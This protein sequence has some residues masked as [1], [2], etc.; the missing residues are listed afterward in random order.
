MFEEIVK[1]HSYDSMEL[2]T[3]DEN[4]YINRRFIIQ[5]RKQGGIKVNEK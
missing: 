5:V 2:H 4:G 3:L 1:L